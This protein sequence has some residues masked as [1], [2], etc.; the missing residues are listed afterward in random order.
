MKLTQWGIIGPGNIAH[1]FIND[2][3]HIK[4]PQRVTAVLGHRMESTMDF[5]REFDI[6][7]Y[8]TSLGEFVKNGKMDAVYIASPHPQHHEQALACLGNKIPVLCEKP[9]TINAEQCEQLIAAARQNNVFLMEGMWLRFLPGIRHALDLIGQGL[10]GNITSVRASI[11][12]KAPRDPDNRYFDPELGGG[13][14]LDL[15]I[16]PVFLAMQILGK[17][18]SVKAIGKLSEEGVD[19]N[20]SI[21]LHYKN[22]SHA[23]LESSLVSSLDVPAEIVGDK[24]I[25]KI[26][27]PWYEKASGI[28]LQT[29]DGKIIYPCH[30]EGH[31]LYFETEEVIRCVENNQVESEL[32]SHDF[33][34]QLIRV[35]DEVRNQIHVTYDM[36]E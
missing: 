29:E 22:G 14:L 25:I 11:S 9:M 31:G 2:F 21:L 15:G 32:F 6:P 7:A 19:E 34:L 30:W 33:S 17:P 1:T 36:Y 26:L 28:E 5:A 35:L 10:I 3:A 4:T 23:T 12:Y 18:C 20:C 16:Y 27:N 13:S 24:G 8:Y